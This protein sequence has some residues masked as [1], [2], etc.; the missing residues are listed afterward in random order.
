MCVHTY[1][2]THTHTHRGQLG[3]ELTFSRSPGNQATSKGRRD[4]LSFKYSPS[5]LWPAVWWPRRC[6][7][8]VTGGGL[9]PI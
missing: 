2:H 1:T 4:A 5:G 7:L 3:Q 8:L 6:Q 9:L